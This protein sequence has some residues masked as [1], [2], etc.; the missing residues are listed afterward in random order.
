MAVVTSPLSLARLLW[1]YGED[2]LWEQA[3][4]LDPETVADIGERA[5]ELVMTPGLADALWPQRP[6]GDGPLL[7]AVIEVFEGTGRPAAL[8]RRRP[9]KAMPEQLVASEAERWFDPGLKSVSQV[10]DERNRRGRAGPPRL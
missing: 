7:I 3:L 4:N 1:W 8:R 10:V 2:R 6:R 5:G 9:A